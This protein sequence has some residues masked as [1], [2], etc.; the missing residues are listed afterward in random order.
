MKK[1][2]YCTKEIDNDS[3]FCIYCGKKVMKEGTN[4][5]A[6]ADNNRNEKVLVDSASPKTVLPKATK[7]GRESRYGCY[8]ML[9]IFVL[10]LMLSFC[11]S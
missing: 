11:S 2:P 10:L 9:I 4:N 5:L 8:F 1:C 3:V 6:Q 7:H